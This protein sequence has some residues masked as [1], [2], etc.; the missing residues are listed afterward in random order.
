[1]TSKK[2]CKLKSPRGYWTKERVLREASKYKLR[3]D[4]QKGS[5]GAYDRARD[6]GWLDE[7]CSHMKSKRKST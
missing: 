4:F 5:R 3:S 1:M 6:M 2:E 7:V